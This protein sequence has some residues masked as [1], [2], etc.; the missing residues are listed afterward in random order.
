MKKY[1]L[2]KLKNAFNRYKRSAWIDCMVDMIKDHLGVVAVTNNIIIGI[3]N[4]NVGELLYKAIFLIPSIVCLK[5][6]D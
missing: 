4:Q 2:I 5:K 3:I 6:S 1:T